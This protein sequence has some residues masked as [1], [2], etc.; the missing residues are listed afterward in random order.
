MISAK[1]GLISRIFVNLRVNVMRQ[2]IERQMKLGAKPTE[3]IEFDPESRDDIPRVLRGI[4]YLYMNKALREELFAP[5]ERHIQAG[6]SWRVGRPGMDVWRI[7][8]LAL[9]KQVVKCDYDRLVEL[10]S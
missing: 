8:G 3:Q 2:V 9:F 1:L 5:L 4:Q 10:A 7:V 6:D